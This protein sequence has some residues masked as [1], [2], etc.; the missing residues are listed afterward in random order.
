MAKF[1]NVIITNEGQKVLF[2]AIAGEYK[3]KFT[4]MAFG[5]GVYEKYDDVY[6]INSLKDEKQ[7]VSITRK[8]DISSDS[9]SVQAQISNAELTQGYQIR[10][11]GIFVKNENDANSSEILYAIVIAQIPDYMPKADESTPL[12][13]SYQF[14][15]GVSNS[16]DVIIEAPGNGYYTQA[17][18]DELLKNYYTKSEIDALING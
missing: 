14:S 1:N 6:N 10:E 13:F 9:I 16:A 8:T 4:S 11:V 7:R 17:E 12:E 2:S 5:A 3:M 18:V 15:L